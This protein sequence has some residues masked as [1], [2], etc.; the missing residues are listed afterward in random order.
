MKSALAVAALGL[1]FASRAQA[2]C[3]LPL[4][5]ATASYLQELEKAKLQKYQDPKPCEVLD[6]EFKQCSMKQ[7]AQLERALSVRVGPD[8]LGNICMPHLAPPE[9][10][11]HPSD[12]KPFQPSPS[13]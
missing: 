2:D 10:S 11:V 3:N 13:K 4:A 5:K 6:A 12:P 7:K 9:P 8:I 1:F